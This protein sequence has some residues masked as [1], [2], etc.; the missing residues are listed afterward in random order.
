MG[1]PRY[2]SSAYEKL[3]EIAWPEIMSPKDK[4]YAVATAGENGQPP[5]A[6]EGSGA[7]LPLPLRVAGDSAEVSLRISD[8]VAAAAAEQELHEIILRLR[9]AE[10]TE[11]DRLRFEM[12]GKE[13]PAVHCRKINALYRMGGSFSRYR[14]S[15][16]VTCTR[17]F[18][19]A[20]SP[21]QPRAGA[22]RQ[23]LLVRVQ[24]VGRP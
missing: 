5:A 19:E 4:S 2:E 17:S 22:C 11:L 6:D 21:A 13:L 3:R 12:N 15:M 1:G 9:L 24:A 7:V 14:I 16:L 8:D 23:Q 20:C 10:T 18:V